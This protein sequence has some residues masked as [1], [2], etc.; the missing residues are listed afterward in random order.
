[1]TR[2]VPQ[3]GPS[4][5]VKVFRDS[6]WLKSAKGRFCDVTGCLET[7]TV[8]FAHMRVG[9]EGGMGLKPADYLGAF[10]CHHHHADQEAHPGF[11]WWSEFVLKSL[12]EE[13]HSRWRKQ[14]D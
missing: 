4:Q 13:R 11:E 12:M 7:E 5:R 1:M 6:K 9:N 3:E 2:I 8:V 10:L 14:N